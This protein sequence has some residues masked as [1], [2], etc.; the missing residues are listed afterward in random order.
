M[1]NSSLPHAPFFDPNQGTE[2]AYRCVASLFAPEPASSGAI[3]TGSADQGSGSGSNSEALSDKGGGIGS[4]IAVDTAA[5]K[6]EGSVQVASSS[7][8]GERA[9]SIGWASE[10]A[11][12]CFCFFSFWGG[13]GCVRACAPLSDCGVI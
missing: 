2:Q 11:T 3:E 12:P 1:Q 6:A 9:L 8:L 7:V 4:G 5:L 13:G 10:R